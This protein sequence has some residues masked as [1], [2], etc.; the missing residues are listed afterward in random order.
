LSFQIPRSLLPLVATKARLEIKVS[1]PM[2][3]IEILG[4]K[5]G[6]PVSLQTVTNPVGSLVFEIEDA[7]VLNI[8]D[9]GDLSLG[10]SAGDPAAGPAPMAVGSADNFW[11][12]DSLALQISAKASDR[13]EED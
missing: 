4:V 2:G 6:A 8:S 13:S 5:N 11:R 9:Q 1:G 3:R 7:E 12:I 10:I